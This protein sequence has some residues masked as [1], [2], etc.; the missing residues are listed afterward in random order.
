MQGLDVEEEEEEL[1]LKSLPVPALLR[2]KSPASMTKLFCAALARNGME[3]EE[4]LKVSSVVEKNLQ[5]LVCYST[6]TMYQW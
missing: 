3:D 4:I 6:G 2:E 1:I 5:S